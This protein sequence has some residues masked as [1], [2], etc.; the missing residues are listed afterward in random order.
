VDN[1]IFITRE[2]DPLPIADRLK[3]EGKNVIVGMI[4]DDDGSTPKEK[5]ECRL[6][7]Y[8]GILEK[9][10]AEHVLSQMKGLSNKD[11]WFVMFDYGDLWEYS[12]R[13]LE[14]G[15][16]KG[17]F[18]TEQGYTLEEDRQ[19]AKAFAQKHYPNLKIAPVHEFSKIEEAIELLNEERDKIFV[20]KS[21]GSN[22]ETVVPVAQDFDLCRRQIIGALRAESKDYEKGG[23]TL[24]E[25]IENPLEFSPVMLFWDGNPLFSLIELENK[26]VGAG[27]IGR[28]SGGCQNLSLQT[29]MD[30][31]INKIAFPPIVYEMAA[32]QPGISIFDAGLLFDGKDFYFTEFCSQRWGWDGIFSEIAMSGTANH[33]HAA[34][35]HF[36]AISSG[37]NPLAHKFGASVRLFQTEPDAER[38]DVY[39]DGY[40][41]DWLTPLADQLFFYCIRKEPVEGEPNGQFV[42]VGYRKDLGVATG[43]GNTP[44]LAINRAYRA[45]KGVAMTGLYYRPKFDFLSRDYFGS[46]MLRYQ[47]L[48]ESELL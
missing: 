47:F 9:H 31:P 19:A 8:D 39:Q 13:A 24:E 16:T 41:M 30:A 20:L 21:E 1:F 22:A 18:P 40:A 44:E 34:S 12:E 27:N 48:L 43:A 33:Q 23:F 15:F 4:E 45:A 25:R 2:G 6:A 38:P 10:P 26:Q 7:L 17:I 32:A 35:L 11:E 14:M 42:S 28:L 37:Q 36:D 46:I 3:D 29:R 5:N